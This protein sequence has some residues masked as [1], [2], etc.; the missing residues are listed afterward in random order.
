MISWRKKV[1]DYVEMRRSLGFKLLDAKIG[2]IKFASFLEQQPRDAHYDSA[3][4]G[5]GAAGQ[6]CAPGGMG[7]AAQFRTRLCSPLERS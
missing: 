1:E 5:M 2:L 3:G 6:D 7:Q 4:D